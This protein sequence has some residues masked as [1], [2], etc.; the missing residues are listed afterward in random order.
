SRGASKLT[1]G[2]LRS[3]GALEKRR[4]TIAVSSPIA[5]DRRR[6]E[7]LTNVELAHLND[8]TAR[9]SEMFERARRSLSGGVASSYQLRD[10]WP[11]YLASGGGATVADA[12]GTRS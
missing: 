10:P 2:P 7:E 5:I 8:R 4:M 1:D 12:G 3:A 9:S 6:V 11:I